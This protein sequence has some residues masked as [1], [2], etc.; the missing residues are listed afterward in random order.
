VGEVKERIQL[1]LIRDNGWLVLATEDGKVIEGQRRVETRQGVDEVAFVTVEIVMG[2][3]LEF[4]E[5][6][7]K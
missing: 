1:K 3:S 2:R 7:P 5:S 4:V 6:E